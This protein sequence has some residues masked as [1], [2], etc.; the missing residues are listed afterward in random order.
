MVWC[1]RDVEQVYIYVGTN[2][3]I[4]AFM[5]WKYFKNPAK[6]KLVCASQ[7]ATLSQNPELVSCMK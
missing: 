2:F 1:W 3:K 4:N 5:L 7:A 6:Y